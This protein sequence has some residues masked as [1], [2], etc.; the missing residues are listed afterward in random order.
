MKIWFLV[1]MRRAGNHAILNWLLPQLTGWVR[2]YNDFQVYPELDSLERETHYSHLYWSSGD[3]CSEIATPAYYERMRDLWGKETQSILKK[4]IPKWLWRWVHFDRMS[5]AIALIGSDDVSQKLP[6]TLFPQDCSTPDHLVLGLENQQPSI[7]P[8]PIIKLMRSIKQI[9]DV[10][11]T[12][13]HTLV[14]VRD[15][16]NQAASFLK[17][18]D[19]DT[20]NIITAARFSEV[21]CEYAQEVLE[22][23]NYLGSNSEKTSIIYD[24]W[25]QDQSYRKSLAHQMGLSG[26]E[27]GINRISTDGGGS[28]FDRREFDGNAEKMR[29]LERWHYYQKDGLFL[30]MIGDK[31]LRGLRKEIFGKMP[32]ELE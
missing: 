7:L 28:S 16:I 22:N 11:N 24:K 30:E 18:S 21:W 20:R 2:H 3:R 23:S 4:Y 26:S 14:I 9:Y 29:V 5:Q 32:D 6:F 19:T 15:P 10:S 31:R 17:L 13:I 27:F 1:G 8:A 12:S 25:F